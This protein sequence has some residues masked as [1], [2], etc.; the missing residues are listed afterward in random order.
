MAPLGPF[1]VRVIAPGNRLT[2]RVPDARH[3]QNLA[4]IGFMGTGKSSV[5]RL[6][7]EQLHFGFLDTDEL[8]EARV[9]KPIPQIFAEEGEAAFRRRESEIVAELAEKSRY[10]FS[11]GG[12]LPINP[13]NFASL[14]AHALVVGLW[15]SPEKIHERVRNQDHRPLLQDPDPLARIRALLAVREPFYRQADVLVNTE[16]RS[17]REVAHHVVHQFRLAVEAAG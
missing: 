6:V 8:I 15:A 13:A 1:F 7:A 4:L 17:V 12:G 14:K 5:G 16:L 10:V 11:T 9:G 3:I 2:A